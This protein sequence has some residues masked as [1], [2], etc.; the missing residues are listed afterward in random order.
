VTM[1]DPP[2]ASTEH[3]DPTGPAERSEAQPTG[4]ASAAST[5]QP[6]SAALRLSRTPWD[7]T[8]AVLVL[9]VPVILAV[10]VYIFFFGGSN[11]IAIDP[12]G[13]YSE[14][15]AANV[16]TVA[17]PTG[18]SNKWK[19]V[20]SSYAVEQG[21]HVLRVG[22]VAPDGSGLQLV[23][24]DGAPDV[25]I[26]DVVG[27]T[28]PVGASVDLASRTWGQVT[29]GNGQHALIS[30]QPRSTIIVKGPASTTDLRTF[31]ASLR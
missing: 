18:L 25:V 6:S 14:A 16:F 9:L 28:S 29:G 11:V 13:T 12:S 19:P 21:R 17:Q 7:M 15:R 30:T 27:T 23:E 4:T 3:A 24:S 20:S 2:P 8:K 10:V 1:T 26:S 5:P 31:A 22:Y